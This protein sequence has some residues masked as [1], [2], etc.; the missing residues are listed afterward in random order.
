MA[1][2]IAAVDLSA[3]LYEPSMLSDVLSTH[4]HISNYV[5]HAGTIHLQIDHFYTAIARTVLTAGIRL[6]VVALFP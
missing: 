1:I 2:F 3:Y 5:D 6:D 4:V